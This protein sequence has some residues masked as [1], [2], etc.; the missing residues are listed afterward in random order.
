MQRINTSINTCINNASLRSFRKNHQI[1]QDFLSAKDLDVLASNYYYPPLKDEEFTLQIGKF[2]YEKYD[3][4][5]GIYENYLKYA[6]EQGYPFYYTMN[7]FLKTQYDIDSKFELKTYIEKY[8]KDNL[9]DKAKEYFSGHL[10]LKDRRGK[11]Y[12]DEYEYVQN[13]GFIYTKGYVHTYYIVIFDNYVLYISYDIDSS[14]I[15]I[16]LH[17]LGNLYLTY[18]DEFEL[19]NIIF[20]YIED[21]MKWEK[22]NTPKILSSK[23][24][25][26][27]L[28]SVIK[29][30]KHIA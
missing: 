24:I 10:Y 7:I 29:Y 14:E 18:K 19:P 22:I 26:L 2:T 28:K 25:E 17:I 13:N 3:G 4:S 15:K 30:K 20:G 8:L 27:H 1:I 16:N 5:F 6:E 12:D 9:Y 23:E 21:N 11:I